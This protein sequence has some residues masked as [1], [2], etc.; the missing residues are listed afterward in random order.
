M[1]IQDAKQLII[2]AKNVCI[3]PSQ[4]T[5]LHPASQTTEPESFTATLAL[6]YTLKELG[7]N[8]NL[9]T[10]YFPEK[11]SFLI[12]S[13]DFI[14][15]P[16]NFVIS[17]PRTK[18]NVSQIYY[19]KNDD[20]LK[21]HLTTDKGLIK[22]E[23][24]LLYF[25]QP[26]PDII[27][28]LG[29]QNF[30]K[31]LKTNLDS[32]GFLL[33]VPIINIDILN[34][35]SAGKPI[36]EKF[37]QINIIQEKSLSEITFELIRSIKENAVTQN[38]AECLLAGLVTYYENFKNIKTN[39]EAMQVASELM[40]LGANYKKITDAIYKA[41]NQEINFLSKIF[42]N[43]TSESSELSVAVLNSNDFYNFGQKEAASAVEKITML[44]IQNDLLVLWQSHAS[45]PTIKGFFYSKNPNLLQKITHSKIQSIGGSDW[46]FLQILGNN[47]DDAKEVILKNVNMG[48]SDSL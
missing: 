6:F 38:C 21:I 11:F 25:S 3:I 47:L 19:E 31:Q 29:I 7:K 2:E 42:Q 16:R 12:P 17:I 39:P 35:L 27:I 24:I 8:V 46:A 36:N 43:L 23:D 40:K 22:K 26:K 14:S 9:L 13:L 48:F 34:P 1:D 30:Q 20:H 44:G 10:E 28:T 45:E 41:S 37:G 32:S 5:I 4:G 33:D 18:A 15:Y